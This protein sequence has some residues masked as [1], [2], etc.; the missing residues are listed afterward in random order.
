L[1]SVIETGMGSGM[2]WVAAS[3]GGDAAFFVIGGK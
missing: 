3:F 1:G 2:G